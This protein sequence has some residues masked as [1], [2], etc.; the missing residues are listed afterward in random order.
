[1]MLFA[2]EGCDDGNGTSPIKC[3]S[4]CLT[5]DPLY[6]CSGGNELGPTICVPNCPDGIRVIEENCDDGN[7]VDNDG[8]TNSCTIDFDHNCT[9]PLNA[10]SICILACNETQGYYYN[11]SYNATGEK[12]FTNYS[13][14]IVAGNEGCDDGNAILSDGCSNGVVDAEF[15]CSPVALGTGPS[16]CTPNTPPPPPTDEAVCGNE[17]LEDQNN[18]ECDLGN[19]MT[20]KTGCVDCKAVRGWK[21]PGN[22][23]SVIFG[24]GIRIK[25][26]EDCD[27]GNKLLDYQDGCDHLMKKQ[28]GFICFSKVDGQE[29]PDG[30][31]KDVDTY[32]YYPV[33][34][35]V[36]AASTVNNL[37]Q[38]I[39]FA[40]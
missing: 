3:D 39:Q 5:N 31:V 23:C 2:G 24:D 34:A 35:T 21:C 15:T 29:F 9:T 11:L 37:L 4:N 26:F 10:I 36:D 17:K 20:E 38:Y 32:C 1:V 14:S 25:E 13:D 22:K 18:E 19:K 27:D 16:V 33:P 12:C 30:I 6:I 40:R 8:C 28:D 7:L